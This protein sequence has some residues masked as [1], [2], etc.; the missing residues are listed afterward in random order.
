VTLEAEVEGWEVTRIPPLIVTKN[1][2]Q[3][4]FSVSVVVPAEMQTSGLDATKSLRVFGEWSYEPDSVLT[5]SVEPVEIFIY[6][7][8]FYEYRVTSDYSFIQ[9][10]P[11]GEFDIDLEITNE[12]NGDDEVTI[13]IDRRDE[14]EERGWAFVFD[15][16]KWDVPHQQT[17]KIPIHVATPRR[18]DGYRDKVAV[19]R[20]N[21]YSEQAIM[22]NAVSE[23]A[24]YSIFIRQRGVSLPGFEPLLM[25]LAV[26]LVSILAFHKRRH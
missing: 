8:Q 11:G 3:I 25:L 2:R 16:T 24:S 1:M 20:F 7:D 12:G 4:G 26:F 18:W 23:Q 9:T 6:I 5:G 22:N 14:M 15:V 17:I 13:D 21:V 19:I 10:S